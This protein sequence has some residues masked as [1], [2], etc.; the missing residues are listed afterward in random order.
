VDLDPATPYRAEHALPSGAGPVTATVRHE[1]RTLVTWT[2][3]Q[4]TDPGPEPDPATEP[5]LPHEI[6]AVEEL[7]MVATH[8]EPYRHAT[9]SPVPYRREA[10]RRDPEHVESLLGLAQRAY[11]ARDPETADELLARATAR[12]TRRHANPRDTRALYLHG[13]VREAMGDDSGAYD[14]YGRA[15]WMRLWRA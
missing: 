10:L 3:P 1:G 12:L 8:L 4:P 7:A 15:L 13:L 14:R 9:R 11:A 6:E 2:E 5:P